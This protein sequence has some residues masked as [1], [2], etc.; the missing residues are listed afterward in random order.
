MHYAKLMEKGEWHSTFATSLIVNMTELAKQ[1][2]KK[3]K[4]TNYD[5]NQ[6]VLDVHQKLLFLCHFL[7]V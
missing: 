3:E 1:G 7:T 6:E 4:K 5:V 2:T